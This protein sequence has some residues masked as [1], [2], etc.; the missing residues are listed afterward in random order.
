MCRL[1]HSA[2]K[3]HP[4][5]WLLLLLF[6]VVVVAVVVLATLEVNQSEHHRSS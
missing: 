1:V 2:L 3:L 6:C 4:S 5:L